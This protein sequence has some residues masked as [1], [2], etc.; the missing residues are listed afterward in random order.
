[1]LKPGLSL[2]LRGLSTFSAHSRNTSRGYKLN[3][4]V[5]IL[6]LQICEVRINVI[7]ERLLY[8][9]LIHKPLMISFLPKDFSALLSPD[10]FHGRR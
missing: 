6:G 1:M 5:L 4:P 3:F 10:L 2:Q 7:G 8:F 9:E